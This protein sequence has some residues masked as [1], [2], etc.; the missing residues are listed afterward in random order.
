[1]MRTIQ[2]LSGQSRPNTG[3]CG[4]SAFGSCPYW[5]RERPGWL[6]LASRNHAPADCLMRKRSFQTPSARV[7]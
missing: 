6:F 4:Q 7:Y 1:M 3:R 2:T 5:V